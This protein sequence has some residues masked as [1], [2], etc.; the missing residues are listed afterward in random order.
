MLVQLYARTRPG[1]HRGTKFCA[2]SR[3]GMP[4]YFQGPPR[5]L[6]RGGAA[7]PPRYPLN[8][9]RDGQ[10]ALK[11]GNSPKRMIRFIRK[12]Y[13]RIR[14]D[15]VPALGAEFAYHLLLSLFPFLLF[16]AAVATFTPLSQEDAL[17]DLAGLAPTAA[18]EVVH[19]T[20][21]E[22][23]D[24]NRV[25]I[26][27]ISMLVTVWLASNGFAA[28]ARGLNKAYD[29]PETR[30]FFKVRA[31]SLLFMLLI[32]LGIL[33]ETVA[34]VFGNVLICR[35]SSALCWSAAGVTLMHALRFLLP[36][37]TLVLIFSLLYT[38]IP[39]RKLTFRQVLPGAAFSSIVWALASFAF[40]FYV[41][42]FANY[43]RLYGSLGGVV[44]LLV[45]LY[46][47]SVVLLIGSEINAVLYFKKSPTK[48]M[49][50]KNQQ[51]R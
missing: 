30:G 43:T 4:R 13:A 20:L 51:L 40:S 32:A 34:V 3:P 24:G 25:N 36:L 42:R 27:S 35:F 21:S 47:T 26:L 9:Q 8:L 48:E 45:W 28:V 14:D 37:L 5:I 17:R 46:L 39:N 1:K 38:V 41:D 11:N 33:L 16:L 49:N 12:L 23:A 15:D 19:R 50:I 10:P 44:I 2:G 6:G 7:E 18:L 31:L 22:I 29:T